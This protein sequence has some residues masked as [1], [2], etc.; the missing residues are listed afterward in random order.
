MSKTG[1]V[2]R[3]PL[4]FWRMHADGIVRHEHGSKAPF[5]ANSEAMMTKLLIIV[6]GWRLRSTLRWLITAVPLGCPLATH[7]RDFS[8][9]P[10]LQLIQGP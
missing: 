9:I 5:D 4:R 1:Q 7:D 3:P 8:Q 2:L 10:N 6:R